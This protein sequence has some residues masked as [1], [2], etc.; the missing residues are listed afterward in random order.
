MNMLTSSILSN[1]NFLRL[2]RCSRI[3]KMRNNVIR[4]KMN[5]KS[6]VLDYIR[7]KQLNWYGRV[8][9]I[10]EERL[11]RKKNW[12]GVHLEEEEE[13]EDLE[14]RGCRTLQQE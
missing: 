5:I 12:N 4:E 6:T 7:C 9:R 14:I 13:K 10:N 1:N 2:V 11:P 3:E 8:Q